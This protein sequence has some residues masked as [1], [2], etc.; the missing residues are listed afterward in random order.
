MSIGQQVDRSLRTDGVLDVDFNRKYCWSGAAEG[1]RNWG[2]TEDIGPR[3]DVGHSNGGAAPRTAE[4]RA[5]DGAEGVALP[6]TGVRDVTPGKILKLHMPNPAL[7][8]IFSPV[9]RDLR[10]WI[11]AM[12]SLVVRRDRE[13]YLEKLGPVADWSLRSWTLL[14]WFSYCH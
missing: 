4:G 9:P 6:T 10:P 13:N 1:L 8:C 5:G 14:Y 2:G 11:E 3:T 7:W 12:R